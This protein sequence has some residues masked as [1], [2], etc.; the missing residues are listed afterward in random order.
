M[1]TAGLEFSPGEHFCLQ[2]SKHRSITDKGGVPNTVQK[3]TLDYNRT[4]H[5]PLLAWCV[6]ALRFS[7]TSV[8][9]SAQLYCSQTSRCATRWGCDSLG[10][11]V[12]VTPTNPV[13]RE[14]IRGRIKTTAPTGMCHIQMGGPIVPRQSFG[15]MSHSRN[16]RW[17]RGLG[18]GVIFFTLRHK[19]TERRSPWLTH[20]EENGLSNHNNNCHH[21]AVSTVATNRDLLLAKSDRSLL[22]MRQHCSWISCVA[23]C[24]CWA[25]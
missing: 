6:R 2:M 8:K 19:A 5:S 23:A 3:Q 1:N 17:G 18:E 25:R 11:V 13:H 4:P 21:P 10:W 9:C 7:D 14:R 15:V 22:K 16:P 12:R 20:G 24:V